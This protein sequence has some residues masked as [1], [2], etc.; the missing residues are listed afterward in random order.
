MKARSAAVQGALAVAGLVAAYL[1]W[2]RPEAEKDADVIVLDA[3]RSDLRAIRYEDGRRTV[4][5]APEKDL[6]WIRHTEKPPKPPPIVAAASSDG[7]VVS[8]DGGTGT[9]AA[10]ATADTDAGTTVPS[11]AVAT[12]TPPSPEPRTREYRA[13]E[14]TARVLERVAPLRAVRSLG[15][16]SPEKREELGLADSERVVEIVTSTGTHRFRASEGSVGTPYLESEEDGR[17]YIVKSTLLSDLEYAQSRLVDRSLHTFRDSGFDGITITV[18][19]KRRTLQR[20]GDK[21]VTSP[22]GASDDF[23]TNWHDRIWRMIGVDVLGRG[24]V[25]AAGEP[26]V[27]VRVDYLDGDETIGHIELAEA[28]KD[29]FARTEHTAG[30]VRLH[31]NA[32][33]IVAEREKIVD[34]P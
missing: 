26:Q 9:I 17:V 30:W 13:N 31:G 32:A 14:A 15:K 7:G 22:G 34:A 29:I 21:L 25:P 23:A 16:L 28:G 3:N 4:E 33:Q 11:P 12:Q 27:R 6:V 2:Q 19:D 24:E 20:S 8:A 18:G 5:L 1:T 10:A